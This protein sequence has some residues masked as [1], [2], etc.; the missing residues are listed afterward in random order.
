MKNSVHAIIHTHIYRKRYKDT[1]FTQN[2]GQQT[3][4]VHTKYLKHSTIVVAL[5]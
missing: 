1:P 3:E 4:R 2:Q 5:G